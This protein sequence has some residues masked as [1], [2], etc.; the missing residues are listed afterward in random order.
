M[1]PFPSLSGSLVGQELHVLWVVLQTAD[2]LCDRAALVAD[3]I[4][5]V[6]QREPG[7]THRCTVE[8]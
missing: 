4:H 6:E 3:L 5:R 8:H 7:E 2:E 1:A